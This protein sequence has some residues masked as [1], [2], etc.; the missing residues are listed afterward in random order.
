MEKRKEEKG[1]REEGGGRGERE[2]RG[3]EGREGRGRKRGE[4][5]SNPISKADPAKAQDLFQ[6]T[7]SLLSFR[8][9]L[10]NP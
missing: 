3:G 5:E 4:R 7:S 6:P 9:E 1:G 8:D 2:E 10:S